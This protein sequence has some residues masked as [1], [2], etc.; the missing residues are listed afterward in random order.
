VRVGAF[1]A[2]SGCLRIL[3]LALEGREKAVPVAARRV[4][5]GDG[6]RE[7]ASGVQASAV[8]LVVARTGA[9]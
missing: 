8:H 5:I 3:A 1:G 9:Q 4:R 2:V 7:D 6:N